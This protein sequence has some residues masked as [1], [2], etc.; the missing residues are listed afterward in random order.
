MPQKNASSSQVTVIH[1]L[2]HR[3]RV[4]TKQVMNP[5]LDLTYLHAT[6]AGLNGI[7][8]VRIN[9]KAA[10]ITIEYDGNAKHRD[11]F[12][13]ALQNIPPDAYMHKF[14]RPKISLSKTVGQ[15][16]VAATSVF[17]PMKIKKPLS[18]ML[19]L[20]TI[21][22]G[23][24]A[25]WNKGLKVEVLDASAV[26]FSLLRHDYT[27][28][29]T[30][31][32]LLGIGNWLEQWT[33]QKS[34]DLLKNLLRPQV[35]RVWIE[36][37][38]KEISIEFSQLKIDDIVICG[39]GELLPVDGIVIG[40]EATLNQSSITGE[41]LP[42]HVIAND[43]VLA[44]AIVIDGR[45]RITA[46]SIGSDTNMARIN[47]F[48]EASL[49]NPSDL[50]KNSIQ[51]ADKLVPITFALGIGLFAITKDIRRA[52][53]VLTVDYS[54]AIKLAAPVAVKSGMH[55][56]G[57]RGVLL[58]GGQA[59]DRLS[60]IDTLVFDKTGT[61]TKGNLKIIDIIPIEYTHNEKTYLIKE[62]ELLALAAG[63]EEH[64]GH[65]VARAIVT[66][67]K[68]RGITLTQVSKVDFVVAHGVSAF[69]DDEHILVGSRHFIE[70]DEHIICTKADA[71]DSQLRN[72]GKSLLFV[73]KYGQLIG[74][75]ALRDEIRE[76]AKYTLTQLRKRGI[77]HIVMLT[78]DH[79]D[80]AHAIA[81]ELGCIDEVHSELKPE[82]KAAIIKKLQ[83]QGKLLAFAGDGVNDAPALVSADVGICMPAGADLAKES[84]QVVLL[85]ENLESLLIARDIATQN[86]HVLKQTFYATVI[87]N[88]LILL[89]AVT[90]R[91]SPVTSALLHNAGTISILAYAA[92]AASK[93][94]NIS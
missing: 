84:A 75:I 74:I 43:K 44:G 59:L 40:G 86:Q 15:S 80:T 82:D 72:Q 66:E 34:N 45:L 4:Y 1:E 28:A 50:Q 29:N 26:L 61:L 20:P 56:A 6:L 64:Y 33:E 88:S 38:N 47:R 21:T 52:A 30:I 5:D 27:T 73:A 32:A 8:S 3:I 71:F 57:Q 22:D 18:W 65:P 23:I 90:G 9:A 37:N 55:T 70:E 92:K 58:K 60:K 7:K 54:C 79:K 35:G 41:S 49:R 17:Q 14:N 48:L 94:P 63:A 77:N 89:L 91:I 39:T 19:G 2:P 10:S 85:E 31:V 24:S 25:L 76:E 42:V 16:L 46:K 68:K 81:H 78:G 12:F 36:R 87:S 67:S 69:V 13:N 83:N 93:Q 53:S 11:S 51:L 62:Q